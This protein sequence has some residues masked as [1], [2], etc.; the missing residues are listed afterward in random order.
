MLKTLHSNQLTQLIMIIIC[1]IMGFIVLFML[2]QTKI[3]INKLKKDDS[4]EAPKLR[5]ILRVRAIILIF[6]SVIAVVSITIQISSFI[7]L[8]ST[9]KTAISH[10]L[11]SDMEK[12]SMSELKDLINNSPKE[13]KLPDNIEG[14][15]I[16]YYRFDCPDCKAIYNDL[17]Q[18]VADNSNIYWISSRSET[19]KALL[20]KYPVDEV[21]TG[22]YIRHDTYNGN[23]TFTK[24]EL[25]TTD[26]D[27][28]IILNKSAIDRL[29]YLQ[30]EGR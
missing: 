21:P 17:S 8:T 29:L 6:I 2:G 10:G 20:D 1:V 4:I 19:G 25:A 18:A 16:I 14:A 3:K 26:E 11:T 12:M 7:N 22:I 15:I 27:G 24:Y 30:S 23:V 5:E 9:I 13:S 28:N